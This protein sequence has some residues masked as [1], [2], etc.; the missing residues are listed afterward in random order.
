M[1]KKLDKRKTAKKILHMVVALNVTK[2]V[3]GLI[4]ENTDL[5]SDSIPLTI[6]CWF[7]GQTVASYTD[8]YTNQA[9]DKTADWWIAKQEKKKQEAAKKESTPDTE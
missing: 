2:Q 3:K 7:V 4:T 5:E 9:V 1:L 6:G 8:P